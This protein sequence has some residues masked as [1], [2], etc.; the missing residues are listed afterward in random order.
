M[1]LK[2]PNLRL[3]LVLLDM[4]EYRLLNGWSRDKKKGSTR[5]DRIPVHLVEEVDITC[6]QDYLQFVPYA[7]GDHFT[8]KDFAKAAHI[9][10]HLAQTVLNIL[11]Y[12]GV[13]QKVGKRGNL[14]FYQALEV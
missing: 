14:F 11:N 12:V 8:S 3:K 2:D 9:P 13:I 7:I 10:V 1:F 6:V 4:E 5:F